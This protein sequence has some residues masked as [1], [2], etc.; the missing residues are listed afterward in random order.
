MVIND[1]EPGKD[2]GSPQELSGRDEILVDGKPQIV[3][4]P[5]LEEKYR[6]L[7]TWQLKC[8]RRG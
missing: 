3:L 7:C 4:N 1:Q 6:D 5:P 8:D 2:E